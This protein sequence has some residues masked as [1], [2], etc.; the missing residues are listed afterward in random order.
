MGVALIISLTH[1]KGYRREPLELRAD[2]KV[3]TIGSWT[4]ITDHHRNEI[5]GQKGPA[6]PSLALSNIVGPGC[7]VRNGAGG[8]E[9]LKPT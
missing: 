5:H 3:R 1:S 2:T 9:K 7:V 8:T 6:Y 4:V